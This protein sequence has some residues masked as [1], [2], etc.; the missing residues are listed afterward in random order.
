[1]LQKHFFPLKL[2]KLQILFQKQ[3]FIFWMK[4]KTDMETSNNPNGKSHVKNCSKMRITGVKAGRF[5]TV[6]YKPIFIRE[7]F[8]SLGICKSSCK[9]R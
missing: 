1:M 9:L 7:N 4:G 8:S 3:V 2:S 6:L 5:Y